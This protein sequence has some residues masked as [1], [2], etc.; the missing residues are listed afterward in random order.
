MRKLALLGA[1]ALV[2]TLAV[3][4]ASAQPSGQSFLT[5]GDAAVV[6]DYAP[7][8]SV[9]VH[10]GRAA[11]IEAPAFQTNGFNLEHHAGR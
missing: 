8:G 5:R 3:A 2:L 9:T 1:S 6:T 10:E 4:S 11:A 7:T